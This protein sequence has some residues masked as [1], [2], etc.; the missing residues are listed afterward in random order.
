MWSAEAKKVL[1]IA[2]MGLDAFKAIRVAA[3]SE[4]AKT[5]PE[6]I[7]AAIVK[8]IDTLIDGFTGKVDLSHLEDRIAELGQLFSANDQAAQAALDAKFPVD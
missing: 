4:Q 3:T 7:L 2:G 6:I 1:L 8:V 5:T